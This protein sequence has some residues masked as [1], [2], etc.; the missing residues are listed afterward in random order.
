[1]AGKGIQISGRNKALQI[2]L[3]QAV[4]HR[5]RNS[6]K[7]ETE[8]LVIPYPFAVKRPLPLYLLQGGF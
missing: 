7:A 4:W 1:M 2:I 5:V 3:E 6:H 8:R